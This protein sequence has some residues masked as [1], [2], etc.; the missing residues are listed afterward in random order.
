MRETLLSAID[1][2]AFL[3][4]FAA[5]SILDANEAAAGL[6]GYSHEELLHLEIGDLHPFE[7]D[8]FGAFARKVHEHGCY[9]SARLTCRTAAGEFL[10]ADITANRVTRRGRNCI[11]AVVRQRQA[12]VA[13][14]A[15]SEGDDELLH[16]LATT[17]FV[18]DHAPEMVLWVTPEGRIHYANQTAAETLGHSR[19]ALERMWIWDVDALSTPEE[20]SEHLQIFRRTHRVRTERRMRRADGTDFPVA[21]TVQ[22]IH[23][24][25]SEYLVSFSRDIT[26]ELRAKQEARQHLQELARLSRRHSLGQMSS[27]MAH[28]VNQ[29]VT[30]VANYVRALQRRLERAPGDLEGLREAASKAVASVE[31]TVDVLQRVQR[32]VRH[33]EPAL[34]E[35]G[36]GVLIEAFRELVEP[37]LRQRGVRLDV[38]L[39]G[40]L[41]PVAADSVMIQQVLMNL[42]RN[43]ADAMADQPE[44]TRCLYLRA[45]AREDGVR[46]EVSDTGPGLDPEVAAALFEPFRSRKAEGLGIGLF[47][48]RTIVESH[49]GQLWHEPSTS[50]TTF[51]FLLPAAEQT[52]LHAEGSLSG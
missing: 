19:H 15:A 8:E 26:D 52:A 2:P 40:G 10:P 41:P 18:L 35:V 33:G 4:D 21:L 5:G 27:A 24:R 42:A 16:R 7:M 22:W 13:P 36:V 9:R 38:T 48:C 43:A 6:L 34:E 30:A 1:E 45:G 46:V 32:Y 37:D 12:A 39:E 29:P 25:G 3:L 23:Y 50:G 28:E 17:Q 20:F 51:C 49:G 47:L 11:L 44:A 14:D 31:R